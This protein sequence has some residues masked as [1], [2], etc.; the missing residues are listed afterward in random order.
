M[1]E[2]AEGAEESE[3]GRQDKKQDAKD[4]KEAKEQRGLR[5]PR[6]SGARVCRGHRNGR[7]TAARA[8]AVSEKPPYPG[9]ERSEGAPP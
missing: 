7:G 4:T 3:D 9:N 2:V 1:A 5:Y 6:A 8:E